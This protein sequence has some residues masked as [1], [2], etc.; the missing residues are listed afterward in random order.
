MG[1]RVRM[2][3]RERGERAR[4]RGDGEGGEVR[5]RWVVCVRVPSLATNSRSEFRSQRP[6]FRAAR[7]AHS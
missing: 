6:L 4:E 3:R 5:R 7:H 2:K 1:V